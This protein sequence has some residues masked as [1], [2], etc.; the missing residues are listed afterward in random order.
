MEEQKDI[1][2]TSTD[3]ES[4]SSRSYNPTALDYGGIVIVHKKTERVVA[5]LFLI[6][7]YLSDNN[8]IRHKVRH[9]GVDLVSFILSNQN[10]KT[11][12]DSVSFVRVY[13]SRLLEITSLL[14]V[15]YLS[16]QISEMNFRVLGSEIE[17][18]ISV[19]ERVKKQSDSLP[20]SSKVS[21]VFLRNVLNDRAGGGM[22]VSG[23]LRQRVFGKGHR[24]KQKNISRKE[25]RQVAPKNMVKK[26]A[27]YGGFTKK[28][29]KTLIIGALSD[30]RKFGV[31]DF[32]SVLNDVGEKTIQR[33]LLALVAQGVLKK[34]GERRWSKYY[35]ADNTNIQTT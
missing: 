4:L 14:E 19:V 23:K 32:I 30:G 34:E 13:A 16:E 31:K 10:N 7:E 11:D 17:R 27:V 2:K 1:K 20:E 28:D 5:A 26:D 8:P 35:L 24:D 18:L 12:S 15:A 25:E 9:L 6:T 33:E 29:R 3:T 21:R 22:T